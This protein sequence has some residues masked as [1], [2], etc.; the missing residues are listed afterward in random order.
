LKYLILII[1]LSTAHLALAQSGLMQIGAR[2]AAMGYTYATEADTW[3]LYNNP[4]GLGY[5]N[6]L[7]ATFAYEHKFALSGLGIMGAGVVTKLPLGSLGVSAFKF[8]DDLY[9]EQTISAS[10]ANKF[11]IASLGIK[12][13]YLQYNIEGFGSRGVATIDFGGIASITDKLVFGA[14]IRNI[15]QAQVS[16]LQDERAPTLLNAGVSYRPSERIHLNVE[17][18]K[19]LDYDASLRAGIEYMLFERI[20]IRAGISTQP[21]TNYAGLGFKAGAL[22]LGYA[23]TKERSLG[24][25]HQG[26]IVYKIKSFE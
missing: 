26:S 5:L 12:L 17:A 6:E 16:E 21:F 7:S 22:E 14:F 25:N 11:G 2:P 15:N 9:N 8:G 10:Y 19:D 4:A 23:M 24:F 20:A 13:N 1:L 18:E 3:S